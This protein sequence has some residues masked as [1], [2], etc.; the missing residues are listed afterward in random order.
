[1]L[2]VLIIVAVV[3]V[4]SFAMYAAVARGKWADNHTPPARKESKKN[5][6]EA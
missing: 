1:M 5:G 3:V 4:I 6:K 2:G